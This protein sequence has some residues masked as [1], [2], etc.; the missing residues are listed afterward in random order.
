MF[1]I[2]HRIYKPWKR[3]NRQ[4]QKLNSLLSHHD[5]EWLF[6]INNEPLKDDIMRRRTGASIKRSMFH[7]LFKLFMSTWKFILQKLHQSD[8]S[9]LRLV[10]SINLSINGDSIRSIKCDLAWR[11]TNNPAAIQSLQPSNIFMSLDEE[12]YLNQFNILEDRSEEIK[13][14]EVKNQPKQQIKSSRSSIMLYESNFVIHLNEDESNIKDLF[15]TSGTKSTE[16]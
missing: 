1:L 11:L 10:Y 3:H 15:F 5:P 7:K 2:Y 6:F 13:E 9:L 14:N 4:Y 16:R 8:Q 12:E